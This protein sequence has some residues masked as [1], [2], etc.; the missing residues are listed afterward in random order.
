M[1]KR[2]L[3]LSQTEPARTILLVVSGATIAFEGMDMAIG[4]VQ[5]APL[6]LVLDALVV[7]AVCGWGVWAAV[8]NNVRHMARSTFWIFLLWLGAG[9][10]R[11]FF[12]PDPGLLLWAPMLVVAMCLAVEHV[13]LMKDQQGGA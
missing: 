7:F 8:K 1:P 3:R 2:L 11:L 10:G 12:S 6:W 9:L 4:L 13:Y 5:G